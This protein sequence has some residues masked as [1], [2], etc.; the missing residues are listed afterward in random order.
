MPKFDVYI[1]EPA[2]NHPAVA[3]DSDDFIFVCTC[4]ADPG[5]I[6]AA[7]QVL[8]PRAIAYNLDYPKEEADAEQ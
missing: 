4:D 1:L 2:I 5:E 7:L 3:I 6:I 8:Y